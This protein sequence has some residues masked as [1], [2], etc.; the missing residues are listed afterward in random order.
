VRLDYQERLRRHCEGLAAIA[1]T[2]GWSFA[3]TSTDRS[4]QSALLALYLRLSAGSRR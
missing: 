4:P 1:R 2:F 3:A